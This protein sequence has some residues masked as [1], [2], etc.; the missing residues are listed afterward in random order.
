[1]EVKEILQKKGSKVGSV[2]TSQTLREALEIL[3]KQK[4]GALL[5]FDEKENIVG[6][7][8][9]RDILRECHKS[10]K[11]FDA[12]QVQKAM[13]TRLIIAAPED[14]VDYI[15]GIMTNNRIRHIPIVSGGKLEGI[16]SIGDVVKAQIQNQ[17][18]ENRYL[19]DYLFGGR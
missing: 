3:V 15:M 13:T 14:K 16:I 10:S 4:I 5:V 1:M 17:E 7:L 8:S 18:Y 12:V 9:E 11:N 6:I 2:K 19:K